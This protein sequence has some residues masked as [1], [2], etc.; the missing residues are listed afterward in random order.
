MAEIYI[1][2]A[3]TPGVFAWIIHTYLKQKYIHVVISMDAELKEAYSVG[4]RNPFI[5][6]LAGF[7]KEDRKKICRAFPEA[8]YMICS[9]EVSEEQKRRICEKLHSDYKNRYKYHYALAGLAALV[10]EIP[11]Y[12]KNHFT[13]SSYIAKLLEENGIRIANK[14]FSLVTPKDFYLYPDKRRIFEGKLN[15]LVSQEPEI[16]QKLEIAQ[17]P[18][19]AYEH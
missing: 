13:C 5:P 6:V 4:R 15:E 19:T 11:F 12:Q 18:E 7:E 9:L 8:D 3:D 16:T 17:K 2:F 10:L 14:H 1:A